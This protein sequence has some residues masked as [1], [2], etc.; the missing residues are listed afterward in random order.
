MWR[1]PPLADFAYESFAQAEIARLDESRLAAL[2]ERIDA[3][4]ALGRSRAAG[5]GARGARPRAPSR[6]R[7]LG[8][9][10]L[11]LYRSGRQA[12]ALEGYREARRRLVEELGLEPG[13]ELQE[14]ERAI[15]AQD[16]A[17]EP[18]ARSAGRSRPATI[19]ARGAARL[20]IAAGGA[21]LL[22][23]LIAVAVSL[24]G[25]GV[26]TVRVA[27]NSLAAIDAGAIVSPRSV[28]VGARPG[29][30]R[31]RLRVAV[32]ANLDDQTVSRVDPRTL[33]TLRTIRLSDPPTGI[34]A[35]GA[36]CGSSTLNRPRRSSRSDR[37][38]PQFD[39]I[40]D[41]VQIGNVVSGSPAAVAA[42]GASLWVAPSSGELTRLDPLTG[43]S[44]R[45]TIRTPARRGSRLGADGA[46]W[47]TDNDADN[48][49]RVDPTGAVTPDRRR[50][51]PERDRGRR[52]RRLGGRLGRRRGGPDRSEH[53]SGDGRRS[54]SARPPTGVAV[55]GG[56][57]WVANSGDGTVTRIDPKTDKV[58]ATIAVGGSP[59]AITV[60]GGRVWVTVDAQTIAD[61]RGGRRHAHDSSRRP[62]SDSMDPALACDDVA[63]LLL[64]ATCVK[65]VNY[66]DKAGAAGS[67]LV[68]EVAQSL[69]TRSS[70]GKSVHVHDPPRLPFLARR[71]PSRSPR[72]RSSTQSSAR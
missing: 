19:L 3:E 62:T 38:D 56:S 12:D 40:G 27:P 41:P 57:V 5:R 52:G 33:Q 68:P 63:A 42:R 39:T 61:W 65:L 34:A 22:A 21:L 31:V 25:S 6:E 36:A 53:Q 45:S 69:P 11:A 70:D 23:V 35:P 71:R 14:L 26:S 46:V 32:G 54:P 43:Q 18:P 49:T 50:P 2:E 47:V 60:A 20:L 72:R 37:I 51:R 9:L 55:G 24:A 67:Q 7:L 66:P 29:R 59:Q 13:R 16:P 15:L 30:D 8:Q 44:S 58:S 64:Y 28:P 17:L 10:M 48:V 4:L 1:G